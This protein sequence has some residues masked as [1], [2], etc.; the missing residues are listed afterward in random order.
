MPDEAMIND[1]DLWKGTMC[2]GCTVGLYRA[3]RDFM[4]VLARRAYVVVVVFLL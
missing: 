2:R 4:S 3:M 1:T